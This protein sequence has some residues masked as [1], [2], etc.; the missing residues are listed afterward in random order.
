VFQAAVGAGA[1]IT[2]VRIGF[3]LAD[4]SPTTVAAFIGADTLFASVRRV[5]AA[6]GLVVT[7]RAHPPTHPGPDSGHGGTRRGLAVVVQ[8][9][10][11]PTR[12]GQVHIA[13]SSRGTQPGGIGWRQSYR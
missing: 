2:P 12:R 13:G 8:A 7:L 4:G 9:M 5:V 3:A 11:N 6:R 10:I 1:M